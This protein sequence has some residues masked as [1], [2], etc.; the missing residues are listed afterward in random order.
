MSVN[1]ILFGEG[2]EGLFWLIPMYQ[3]AYVADT[4]PSYNTYLWSCI[5]QCNLI[6]S[7]IHWSGKTRSHR[8][9]FNAGVLKNE[10]VNFANWM[11]TAFSQDSC[12]ME[13]TTNKV[14]TVTSYC[15]QYKT[16]MTY[17][18]RGFSYKFC[19]KIHVFTDIYTLYNCCKHVLLLYAQKLSELSY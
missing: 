12:L 5:E 11:T 14:L 17:T 2:N 18:C 16:P 4:K 10:M 1:N 6:Y 7:A 19:I 9:L 13:T 3:H 8:W 15:Y